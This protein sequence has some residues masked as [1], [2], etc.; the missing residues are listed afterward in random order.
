MKT[1]K[2]HKRFLLA[3]LI[4]L[5]VLF[6]PLPYIYPDNVYCKPCMT[7]EL[8]PKCPGKGDLVWTSSVFQIIYSRSS[9][10]S[11]SMVETIPIS[12]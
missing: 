5:I 10:V 3:I 8:C 1:L 4:I 12:P 6:A 7:G 2:S 11:E 9:S